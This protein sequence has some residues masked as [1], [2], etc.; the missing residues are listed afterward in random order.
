MKGE[1]KEERVSNH[2]LQRLEK[3]MSHPS[4]LEGTSRFGGITYKWR[5]HKVS[6]AQVRLDIQVHETTSTPIFQI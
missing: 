2:P 6:Q 3:D 1:N 4:S 5:Y